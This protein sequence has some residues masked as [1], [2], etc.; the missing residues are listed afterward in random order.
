MGLS[1][2]AATFSA[3]DEFSLGRVDV[4]IVPCVFGRYC[5]IRPH[6]RDTFG[7]NEERVQPYKAI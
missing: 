5:Y 3:I 7:M 6:I 4:R 2:S 1:N